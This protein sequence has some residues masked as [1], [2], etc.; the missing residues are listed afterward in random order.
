MQIPVCKILVL[1]GLCYIRILRL[2]FLGERSPFFHWNPIGRAD[3]GFDTY[4]GDLFL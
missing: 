2:D 1:S 4:S 3:V